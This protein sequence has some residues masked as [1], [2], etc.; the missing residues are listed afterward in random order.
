MER[1]Y[2]SQL[3]VSE[4]GPIKAITPAE[5]G[6]VGWYVDG[7]LHREDGPA[8]IHADGKAFYWYRGTYHPDVSDNQYWIKLCKLKAFW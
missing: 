7:L 5:N 3:A 6:A 8:I 1:D 4:K 2:G